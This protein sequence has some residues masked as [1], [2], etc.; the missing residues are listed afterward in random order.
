M[1]KD[2]I[3]LGLLLGAIA[4]IIGLFL[5]KAYKF[6]I[7]SYKEFFQFLVVEPGFR[8]LSVALSLSLLLNALIFTV[9]INAHKDNTAKG[10]FIFTAIY[11]LVILLI[12]TFY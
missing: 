1:K 4:P 10:I 5:F 7:F 6:G 2:S 11:G 3:G 8:T 12:K 9:F